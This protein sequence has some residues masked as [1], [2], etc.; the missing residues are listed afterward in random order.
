MSASACLWSA[1]YTSTQTYTG[2]PCL[3]LVYAANTVAGAAT[4]T[5]TFY[6]TNDKG[7]MA[8]TIGS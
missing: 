5:Y 7:D 6:L 3:F 2:G 8:T 4:A 1:S